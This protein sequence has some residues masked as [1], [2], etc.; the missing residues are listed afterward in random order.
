MKS[1]SKKMKRKQQQSKN[2]STVCLILL[3]VGTTKLEKYE[4]DIYQYTLLNMI[5]CRYSGSLQILSGFFRKNNRL[6]FT[7][8][9]GQDDRKL[10]IPNIKNPSIFEYQLLK[11]NAGRSQ[12]YTVEGDRNQFIAFIFQKKDEKICYCSHLI[13]PRNLVKCGDAPQPEKIKNI[14]YFF[15]EAADLDS[16]PPQKGV[17]LKGQEYNI[18][19]RGHFVHQSFSKLDL[20]SINDNLVELLI[21]HSKT[22]QKSDLNWNIYEKLRF[23]EY[24]K[25]QDL[26]GILTTKQDYFKAI[27]YES[28]PGSGKGIHRRLCSRKESFLLISG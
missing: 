1:S 25:G 17:K 15:G 19:K 22:K 12:C 5:P 21:L 2:L 6:S 16:V 24:Q 27:T 26:M 14:A 7:V 9:I 18:L 8:N 13:F 28:K 11:R 10:F 4:A 20:A 3:W 23:E